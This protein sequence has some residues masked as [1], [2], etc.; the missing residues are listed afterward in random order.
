MVWQNPIF[1]KLSVADKQ[2]HRSLGRL[3]HNLRFVFIICLSQTHFLVNCGH[4]R[5]FAYS[6]IFD[7]ETPENASKLHILGGK[8][9]K[10]WHF[11]TFS[12]SKT[13]LLNFVDNENLSDCFETTFILMSMSS[14]SWQ[15]FIRFW[16]ERYRKVSS[17]SLRHDPANL[18]KGFWK[19]PLS[20][21]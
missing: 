10:S 6:T 5:H 4:F 12:K 19:V 7:L 14:N 18:N 15:L 1:S 9:K 13:E 8:R 20:L 2:L 11:W 3:N 17:R 21:C 16:G